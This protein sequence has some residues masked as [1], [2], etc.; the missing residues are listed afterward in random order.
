MI[1]LAAVEAT[2]AVEGTGERILA[3]GC[4]RRAISTVMLCLTGRKI[5]IAGKIICRAFRANVK[6]LTR[7][8]VMLSLAAQGL[9]AHRGTNA[10]ARFN[11]SGSWSGRV[12]R[13][14]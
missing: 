5:A 6:A 3:A 1:D 14:G 4:H 7:G 13:L 8:V 10:S 11:S 12:E 9:R 2:V